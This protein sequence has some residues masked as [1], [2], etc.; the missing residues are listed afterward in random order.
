[1]D[2][3]LILAILNLVDKNIVNTMIDNGFLNQDIKLCENKILDCFKKYKEIDS[4]FELPSLENIKKSIEE[5]VKILLES[6]KLGIKTTNIFNDDFPKKLKQIKD[7]SVLIFYKGDLNCLYEENSIAIIGTRT[8][9]E[10]GEKI[11]QALGYYYAKEGFTVVSGLANGCDTAGHKGCLKAN[12][13]TI[14]T[15]PCGLDKC[16]PNDDNDL[17]NEIVAKGGCLISEYKIGTPASSVNFI[18]RDRLQA[19]LSLGVAVVECA[20]ECGTM[21][22]V[23]FAEEYGKKVAVSI[24]K[25]VKSDIETVKG[26]LYLLENNR[27][28]G[29]SDI[30]DYKK[31]KNILLGYKIYR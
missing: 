16:Y 21:H 30:N 8:P 22:T 26:N 17:A 12:G 7:R 13:K 25:D 5:S 10:N 14:A 18:E 15:L 19:A 23:R 9:T 3:S 20:I 4:D 11:G 24:H 2:N 29:L 28:V 27:A 6:E 1:M 31:Y